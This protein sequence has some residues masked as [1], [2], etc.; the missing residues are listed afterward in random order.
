[1]DIAASAVAS[2]SRF[3]FGCAENHLTPNGPF[4]PINMVPSS[5]GPA[6]VTVHVNQPPGA[7]A[8]GSWDSDMSFGGVSIALLDGANVEA[9]MD[10]SPSIWVIG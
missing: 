9:V 3:T 5:A 1:M 6:L 4:N 7:A 8:R 10:L 2:I